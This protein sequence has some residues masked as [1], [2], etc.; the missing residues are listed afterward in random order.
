VPGP[1]DLTVNAVLPRKPLLASLTARLRS[2]IP[3]VHLASNPCRLKFFGQEIVV[4]RDDLMSRMLRN[5]VGVKPDARN[6]DLK[7]YVCV[8]ICIFF[9]TPPSS[10]YFHRDSVALTQTHD[11][12][13]NLYSIKATSPLS[14]RTYSRF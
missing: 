9:F 11:S 3:K 6:E 12:S 8:I 5:L 4:S 1:S 2:K 10:H 13:C 7:R 14:R